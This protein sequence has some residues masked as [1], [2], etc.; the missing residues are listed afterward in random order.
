MKQHDD[1]VIYKIETDL[2]S[3]SE[4]NVNSQ[5][6]KALDSLI[7]RGSIQ[8]YQTNP[9]SESSSEKQGQKAIPAGEQA[10]WEDDGGAVRES[11]TNQKNNP[12]R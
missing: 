9:N 5:P 8:H 1:R 10:R 2:D 6:N 11:R 12:L 4:R 7:E 3:Q